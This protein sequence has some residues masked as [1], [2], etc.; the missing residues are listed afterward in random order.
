MQKKN[1]LQKVVFRNQKM[2]QI[3]LMKNVSFFSIML[4]SLQMIIMKVFYNIL[5]VFALSKIISIIQRFYIII[6][7]MASLIITY[8]GNISRSNK[9]SHFYGNLN[10][11]AYFW[12]QLHP[13]SLNINANSFKSSFTTKNLMNHNSAENGLKCWIF[14]VSASYLC[15]V[16]GHGGTLSKFYSEI[17]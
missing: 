2:S 10:D 16:E 15:Q 9:S 14:S 4:K 12:H 7:Q 17:H 8:K 6:I 13:L 3:F 11:S 1:F 5:D